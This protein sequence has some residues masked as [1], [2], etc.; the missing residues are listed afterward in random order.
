[1][2]I[3]NTL[4][5]AQ[6]G[7]SVTLIMDQNFTKD[8]L[9]KLKNGEILLKKENEFDSSGK[10]FVY[11]HINKSK[12]RVIST[13]FDYEHYGEFMPRVKSCEVLQRDKNKFLVKETLG[14]SVLNIIYHTI[15]TIDNKRE[16]INIK[17]D[18][19]SKNS[20]NDIEGAYKLKELNRNKTLVSY[21]L[22][23]EA[24]RFIPQVVKDSLTK[25]DLPNILCNLKRRVESDGVWKK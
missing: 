8:D 9:E 20:V 12:E 16:N 17:L 2:I 25:R 21:T 15:I 14:V 22:F 6:F 4:V 18:K 23:V 5:H 24:G 13:I 11:G 7:L 10:W 3:E 19:E 1:M